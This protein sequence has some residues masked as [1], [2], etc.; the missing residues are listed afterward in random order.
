MILQLKHIK[1]QLK[2]SSLIE[3]IVAMVIMSIVVSLTIGSL[4]R[5]SDSRLKTKL[6]AF[7]QLNQLLIKNKETKN[8]L[9][10]SE[11]IKGFEIIQKVESYADGLLLLN[12]E[13]RKEG[14]LLVSLE[15]VVNE[16]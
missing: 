4:Y 5:L 15:E 13:A 14:K 11:E 7:K 9:A 3:I 2:S 10:Y 12:L 1:H 16:K 6:S 8:Y